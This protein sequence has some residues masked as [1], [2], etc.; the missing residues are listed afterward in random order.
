LKKQ[1]NNKGNAT[2]STIII[3]LAILPAVLFICVSAVIALDGLEKVQGATSYAAS[4]LGTSVLWY[5]DVTNEATFDEAIAS[6]TVASVIEN[7]LSIPGPS[8]TYNTFLQSYPKITLHYYESIAPGGETFVIKNKS[9]RM[10]GPGIIVEVEY[11]FTNVFELGME[12]ITIT[13]VRAF[14]ASD[15]GY[16]K[17]VI[18][19]ERVT[20]TIE[21]IAAALKSD[22]DT[23]ILD[24]NITLGAP[25]V[26]DG[27]SKNINLNGYELTV[28]GYPITANN[29]NSKI[30]NGYVQG[31]AI[32]GGDGAGFQVENIHFLDALVTS[33]VSAI[34]D[35]I[36][37][38]GGSV[39]LAI[40]STNP[41]KQFSST[42]LTAAITPG[43]GTTF[44]DLTITGAVTA[45]L[46]ANYENVVFT[47]AVTSGVASSSFSQ[48]TF[49][50]AVTNTSGVGS[51]RG[52]TFNAAVTNTAGNSDYSNSVFLAALTNTAGDCNYS[53]C[54]IV[55]SLFT[56]SSG[57][58]NLEGVIYK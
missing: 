58:V 38:Y 20:T 44:R 9:M 6:E 36:S 32:L 37:F 15:A 18:G 57:T 50:G 35:N 29:N 10:Q 47:G 11:V 2:L 21:L 3:F 25:L 4:S 48:C 27:A 43:I 53:Y 45:S 34:N 51:Y 1:L 28:S 52:S 41:A 56:L 46:S 14:E 30:S 33:N 22:I 55:Q 5:D 42:D 26:I 24:G 31:Q 13:V 12:P 39:L 7:S 49:D 16:I 40:T 54:E 19:I 8:A 23:I 17:P